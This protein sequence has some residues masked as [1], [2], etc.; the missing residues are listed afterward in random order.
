M[1]S[2]QLRWA[3]VPQRRR[4][5]HKISRALRFVKLHTP[6]PKRGLASPRSIQD[7]L[8]HAEHQEDNSGGVASAAR[9]R[10]D[11]ARRISPKTIG[12]HRTDR[13]RWRSPDRSARRR[14]RNQ[15]GSNFLQNCRFRCNVL[16]TGDAGVIGRTATRKQT[17]RRWPVVQ[18]ADRTLRSRAREGTRRCKQRKKWRDFRRAAG[19]RPR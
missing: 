9:T 8:W 15:P 2:S 13:A 14:V 18:A 16:C 7:C 6:I 10:A 19:Y 4:P 1:P 5:S 11:A 12:V 17:A 3:V